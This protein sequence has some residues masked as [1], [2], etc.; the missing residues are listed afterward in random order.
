MK[1]SFSLVAYP[2]SVIK[3]INEII[4]QNGFLHLIISHLLHMVRNSI[5]QLQNIYM[6]NGFEF[7]PEKKNYQLELRVVSSSDWRRGFRFEIQHASFVLSYQSLL[8]VINFQS[9][10]QSQE[11]QTSLENTF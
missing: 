1:L 7:Y 8:F 11:S 10:L 5:P 2:I 6:S 9:S 4:A 3:I